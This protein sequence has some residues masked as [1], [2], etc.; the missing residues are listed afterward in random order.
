MPGP[1]HS[2]GKP[3]SKCSSSP[4]SSASRWMTR[5]MNSALAQLCGMS[6]TFLNFSPFR[7]CS[8]RQ[9]GGRGVVGVRIKNFRRFAPVAL[10][11]PG[12]RRRTTR[13]NS[14]CRSRP[15]RC[16]R[17]SLRARWLRASPACWP[18]VG[19]P[20][21]KSAPDKRRGRRSTARAAAARSSLLAHENRHVGVALRVFGEVAGGGFAEGGEE[22]VIFLLPFSGL[23]RL[24]QPLR[25]LDERAQAQQV[26]VEIGVLGWTPPMPPSGKPGGTSPSSSGVSFSRL[27]RRS[28]WMYSATRVSFGQTDSSQALSWVSSA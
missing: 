3:S 13:S 5:R 24:A 20:G 7:D 10:P 15:S 11:Q 16:R 25:G 21:R 27:R 26:P 8:S 9:P 19:R 18:R 28:V 22:C 2:R 1:V 4:R 6:P 23:V 12:V 14:R 17:P